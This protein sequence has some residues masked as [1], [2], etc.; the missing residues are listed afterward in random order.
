MFGLSVPSIFKS[1]LFG[2]QRFSGGG[3]ALKVGNVWRPRQIMH[4]LGL[5]G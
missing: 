3:V 5:Q 1:R 4:G 2:F